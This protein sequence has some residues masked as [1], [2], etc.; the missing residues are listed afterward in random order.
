MDSAGSTEIQARIQEFLNSNPAGLSRALKMDDDEGLS[1]PISPV[2]ESPDISADSE[3]AILSRQRAALRTYIDSVPYDCES[4]EEMEEK[5]ANIVDMI[6]ISAKSD[7]L[8]LMRSWDGVLSTWLLLKYPIVKAKRIKLLQYYYNLCVVPAD[9]HLVNERVKM[10]AA[11]LPHKRDYLASLGV[12]DLVLDWRPLWR[13]LKKELWPM[14]RLMDPSRNVANIYLQLAEMSKRFFPGNEV[15]NILGTILP[16]LS[17]DTFL[18]IVPVLTSFIPHSRPQDYLPALF[19]IWETFNSNIVD[20]RMI[21]LM[22]ELAEEHVSGSAGPLGEDGATA[23]SEVGIWNEQQWIF[24]AGKCLGSMNVP[25]GGAKGASTTAGHADM[26]GM[27]NSL[28]IKKPINKNHALAKLIVYSISVDGPVRTDTSQASHKQGQ[29]HLGFLAGSKALDSLERIITSAETYFHP[30]NSG[31]WTLS[32]SSFLQRLASEFCKR[33]KEEEEPKCKTPASQRL[34]HAT[35]HSFVLLLRTPMLLALFAKD[36]LSMGLA[37]GALRSLAL[38]EPG[39]VM[40][41][42]LERAYS[43]LEVVNETHRTTAVL[44]MLSGVA[45]PLVSER[46]WRGGQ[47]HLIPLL[48]LCLPGIDLNDPSKTICATL[49]ICSALQHVRVGD[50]SIH[51]QSAG[52][53]VSD[54][55]PSDEMSMDVEGESSR[56]PDGTEGFFPVL[57]KE[58]E[59]TLARDST[60]GFA[61][62][63][64]S[65]FR[66]VFALYENLPE[67]GGRRNTTGGK[68]EESVLRSIKNMLDVVCLHLSDPLFDLVLRVVYDYATTNT[69]S[70]AVRAIGQLVACLARAKPQLTTDKFLPF[71]VQQIKE[72]LKHGASSI[73]TTS[74]H[75]AVPSDTTLHWNISLLRGCL[76]YGGP[77]LLKHKDIILD[78]LS[79][80]IDKTKSERGFSGAGRLI[81][82]LLHTLSGVYPVNSRLVN[83]DEWESEE[84]N[85]NHNLY[86]GRF[87]EAK[88]V[89]IEWHVPSNEEVAFVLQILE[90]I[91]EPLLTRIEDL[92]ADTNNWD[93][94]ARNDFCRYLYA[95][96][97][98]WAGLPTFI[99][100][101]LRSGEPLL[102]E[103]DGNTDNLRAFGLPVRAGFVL[104]NPE[105]PK[106]QTATKQRARF[107]RVIHQAAIALR[108]SH[109]GEDHIDAVISVLRALDT[110][111]LEYGTS[112]ANYTALQKNYVLARDVNRMWPRQKENTR[113]VF[114]KRAQVYHNARLVTHSINRCRTE[115]DTL[116][117]DDL[118]ECS[119]SPYTRVRRHGQSVLFSATDTYPLSVQFVLP[120]MIAALARGTDPDTMKGALY[121]LLH[122]NFR[123]VIRQN[124]TILSNLV[125]ALLECQHQEKPSVQKLV[126]SLHNDIVLHCT[127]ENGLRNM[128]AFL[129]GSCFAL[130]LGALQI[131]FPNRQPDERVLQAAVSTAARKKEQLEKEFE[132]LIKDVIDISRRPTTHWRYLQMALQSL[133]QRRDRPP[134]PDAAETLI[135]ATTESHPLTRLIAQKGLVKLLALIKIR[136]YANSDEELWFEEWRNPLQRDIAVQDEKAIVQLLQQ[137]FSNSKGSSSELCIDKITSGFLIWEPVIKAYSMPGSSSDVLLMWES[138]SQAALDKIAPIILEPVYFSRLLLL[139]AQE[140]DAKGAMN[141][142]IDLRS[143]N[144]QFMKSIAKTFGHKC[145]DKILPVIEALL[146]DSNRF[147]QRAA[148]EA[149]SG[150]IRGSKNWPESNRRALWDWFMDR[151]ANV[152]GQ[153]KPDTSAL[154]EAFFQH[155]LIGMDPQRNKPLV[156]WILS[157]PLE[158]HSDSAF[159][160]SKSLDLF[161]ALANEMGVRFGGISDHYINL[162]FDNADTNYAEI[163]MGIA[164]NMY[165]LMTCEWYLSYPSI[166]AFLLACREEQDPLRIRHAKYVG[167]IHDLIEKLSVWKTERLP[168]PRV[169]Q[170]QFDKVSL[171]ALSWI[172]TIG[173]SSEACTMFPYVMPMLPEVLKMTELNDNRELT[174]YSS[175]VLFIL[176]AVTPPREYA[177]MVAQQFITTLRQSSSYKIKLTGLPLLALFYYRNLMSVSEACTT[178]IMDVIITCLADEN[179]EVREVAKK[180]LSGLL[181]CTQR[182]QILPLRNRFVAVVR[183]TKLPKR[184]DPGYGD[185]LRTLHSA[186]LGLCALIESFPYSIEPWMPPLTEGEEVWCC[187][188]LGTSTDIVSDFKVLAPHA[189]DPPPISTA[190]RKTASEFKKTHQDTWHVD[191][192]AF[193]EDQLQDLSSMLVG[194]SYYA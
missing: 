176:S 120:R 69:K 39:L 31:H 121:V 181:R 143:D 38:L 178:K 13:V 161:S 79:V 6:Y 154:W 87:Y 173:H 190:I 172:W 71:C 177:E 17:P 14:K 174:M 10:F 108:G 153:I 15:K 112:K 82:R 53:I 184:Q 48:E 55:G 141:T 95:V 150:L 185:A 170:S 36:P 99:E 44:S 152:F 133:P 25:I 19:S 37:Q 116:L 162:L 191:Q 147:S 7:Q 183:G 166:D 59:R 78:L 90:Q 137:P 24:L 119:L 2:E 115:F 16:L 62:W 128:A 114:L 156:D 187:R 63:V 168:P 165:L 51:A 80:L 3:E 98:V 188:R 76:G 5:L 124:Y 146:F 125:I 4:P 54:D 132:K 129:E 68:S 92:L 74:S 144:V 167:R 163:R 192:H 35:R 1:T 103:E 57:S 64:T 60:A 23:W 111:L 123:P 145:L 148:A 138:Q 149:L 84:F 122:K 85:K 151:V 34:T 72:E 29:G 86:W 105:D 175:G 88:E 18:S 113:L 45:L 49:F 40:P 73:R 134:I 52:I 131:V 65:L 81:L 20:E 102:Q 94:A 83:T 12:K 180:L 179:I 97:S 61:D 100:E 28:R 158:F 41:Q 155:I 26:A 194:T 11:L 56:L 182:R 66:R 136:S 21:E 130:A 91:V 171:T 139:W 186:I 164:Q 46:L 9:S 30:S 160:M 157:L 193:N 89:K 32:L 127:V 47:K 43:G 58:E 110:Y 67:E 159:T 142:D 22:A 93:T 107:G 77:A 75:A 109:G 70:N 140:A 135:K 117:F 50:L 106:Y 8:D 33:W 189:S 96:R 101:P 118:I 27:K 104:S 126:S 169:T 42:L